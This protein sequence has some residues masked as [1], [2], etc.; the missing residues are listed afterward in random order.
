[1]P[2]AAPYSTGT[3]SIANG[4][5]TVTGSGTLW[6]PALNAQQGDWFAAN[7][8]IGVIDVV[9]DDTHITLFDDW[10]GTTL[11]GGSYLIFKSSFN[12]YDPAV[13]QE[14]L[15]EF[16]AA[17]G[18]VGKYWFVAGA[19]PD[20][21]FGEDGDFALKVNA[22][23]WTLW[24]KTGGAW[25]QQ[26][27]PAGTTWRGL[28]LAGTAY[29]VNDVTQRF[30]SSY[31]ALQPSTNK[32]P[33]SEP[34]YWD[35]SASKGETGP[36]GGAIV[37]PVTFSTA[38]LDQ[39][40]GGGTARLNNLVQ[41]SA[42]QMFVDLLD[43]N[44]ID[45]TATFTSLGNRTSAEKGLFSLFKTS[46]TSVRIDGTITAVT[47]AAGYRKLAITVFG[48]APSASPFVNGDNLS[49][50][51]DWAGDKGD[52]GPSPP[53]SGTSTTAVTVPTSLPTAVAF[54][55]QADLAWSAG[56][57]LLATSDDLTK[58]IGGVLQSYVGTTLTILADFVKGSGSAS[59][60]TIGISGQTGASAAVSVASTTTGAAG[61]DAAVTNGGSLTDVQL[62]FTIPRGDQGQGIQPDA[63]GTLAERAAHD[64]ELQDFV[65]LRTDI[66]PFE[67]Y[68]KAS[69]TSGDWA[70]PSPAGGAGDMLSFNNLS[71]LT[72]VPLA[73]DALGLGELATMSRDDLVDPIAMAIV[74]GS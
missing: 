7:G 2:I 28:W 52:V 14:K 48:S 43:N 1:M 70:G 5:K 64:N 6:S 3:A 55:T 65:Y 74:F 19:A 29:F 73:R 35:L 31:V 36:A 42:T 9:T 66:I 23:P 59:A 21:G 56:Q 13:N 67:I 57:R 10:F 53:I 50:T 38:T 30:G 62:H 32:P 33:E 49:L 61:S 51:L 68:I 71:E 16:L 37:L 45:R 22:A 11:S 72:D 46:N 17:I 27:Q 26:G 4:S 34:T 20:P 47:T 25:V 40:P 54:G 69:A 18:A 12:R 58:V 39:D 44:N 15:A 63:T 24:Y 41:A 8:A 60:W